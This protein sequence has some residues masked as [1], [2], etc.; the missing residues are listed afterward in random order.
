MPTI[1]KNSK[2]PQIAH[3]FQKQIHKVSSKNILKI[4]LFKI[5][6]KIWHFEI[7]THRP[8]HLKSGPEG[9]VSVKYY[10]DEIHE[11]NLQCRKKLN[12]K[13]ESDLRNENE[14]F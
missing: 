13:M 7:F 9:P 5:Y 14:K 2:K 4:F 11:K 8:V 10:L 6:N 12:R 1:L 3:S